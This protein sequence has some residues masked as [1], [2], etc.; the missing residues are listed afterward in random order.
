ML[1]FKKD[2]DKLEHVWKGNQVGEKIEN[3]VL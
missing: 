2:I 1:N 3:Y